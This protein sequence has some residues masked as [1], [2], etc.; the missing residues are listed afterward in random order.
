MKLRPILLAVV[1]IFLVA[2][3]YGQESDLSVTKTG[4][5]T[6]DANT[7]VT[8]TITVTNIG[9]DDAGTVTMN[10][11]VAG[12]WSF[13]S[14]N[15]AGA[16]GFSCTDPGAGAT[17]GTV[18][19]TAAAMT[20]NTSAIFTITF[21]I[22]PATPPGTFFT[23]VATAS[24]ATDPND[25]NNSGSATTSTPPPDQADL[26]VLKTGPSQSA[27][28]DTDVTFNITLTNSGPQDASNLTLTDTLQ[29]GMTFVSFMQNS[30]PA[31][32]CTTGTTTTC[33]ATTFAAGATATFTIVGHIPANAAPPQVFTN[34]VTATSDTEDPNPENN[35][36]TASVSIGSAD[37]GVTKSAPATAVGGTNVTYVIT[38]SS[39]GPS[40]ASSATLTDTLPGGST[41][42]SLTQDTGPAASCSTPFVG[43]GGTVTCTFAPFNNGTS[44]QFS[45]TITIGG[46]GSV[47]NTAFF[48]SGDTGDPNPG[49]NSA[50]ATTTVSLSSD[51]AMT[52]SGPAVAAPGTD[53]SYTVTITNNGPSN[54]PNATL[55]DAVPANTTFVSAAQN[56]GPVFSCATPAVGG[57]G[58]IQCSLSGFAA[59]AT[60]SFT[61]V[62][63]VSPSAP[64]AS[65]IT[66]TASGTPGAPATDPNPIN[67]S[68][69]AST[70]VLAAATDVQIVKTAPA[71]PNF[72]TQPLTFTI[73]VTNN[74]PAVASNVVVTDPLPAGSTFNSA[75]TTQGSC[76]GGSPTT[77]SLGAML[78]GDSVTITLTVTPSAAGPLSNTATVT[79]DSPDTNPAN[80]SST[81]VATVRDIG[82][83]PVFSPLTLAMLALMMAVL[84]LIT[85]RR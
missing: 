23:N 72:S 85:L 22:P 43:T 35:T 38:V 17:S 18:S 7:N 2:A 1:C 37:L 68:A 69:S 50:T 77:C 46:S 62:F 3:A 47:S 8:F 60:A 56:S 45:L 10:D 28:P 52:K 82:T 57:T 74:G 53:V 4:P 5:S 11:P 58:N 59:S 33:S 9:P 19:C 64:N 40:N 34:Q 63:H 31:L 79:T 25:E 32:S 61:F 39:S 71:G 66:N 83:I 75:T 15:A 20:A 44:A 36:A 42:V 67:D 81:A 21:H 30:G 26:G 24:T 54:A 14:V 16:P 27:A 78:S 51:I 70:Q 49:N 76:T 6:A 65:S 13:F 80:N 48:N 55:T 73:V 84:A 41:F 12:G 29:S